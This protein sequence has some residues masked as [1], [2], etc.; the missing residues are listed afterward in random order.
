MRR[1]VVTHQRVFNLASL[2][3]VLRTVASGCFAFTAIPV[4]TTIKTTQHGHSVIRQPTMLHTTNNN[5]DDNDSIDDDGEEDIITAKLRR[6][7]EKPLIDAM[8]EHD[9]TSQQKSH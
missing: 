4:T 5:D 8:K 7:S 1:T 6:N 3:L 9:K 2:L